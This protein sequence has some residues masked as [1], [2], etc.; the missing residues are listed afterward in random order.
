MRRLWEEHARLIVGGVLGCVI[1][2][3]AVVGAVAAGD[4]GSS[5]DDDASLLG[6]PPSV[7]ATVAAPSAP[8]AARNAS[9]RLTIVYEPRGAGGAP[10]AA[11]RWTLT[12]SPTGGTLPS[13]TTACRQLA[14]HG[15]DLVNPGVQCLVIVRGGRTATVNGTWEGK[16]VHF[17]ASTCSRAWTTLPAVLTGTG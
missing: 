8:V 5:A 14:A 7:T 6:A 10:S 9:T 4:S 12:C 16:P 1:L 13:R 17:V 15:A 3:S 11:H 2:V